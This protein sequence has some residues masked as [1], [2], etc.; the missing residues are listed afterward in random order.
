LSIAH[1]L[2]KKFP[3]QHNANKRASCALGLTKYFCARQ[4]SNQVAFALVQ[5]KRWI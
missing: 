3:Q 1:H 5:R 4:S 2:T